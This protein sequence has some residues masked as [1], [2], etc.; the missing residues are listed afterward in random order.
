MGEITVHIATTCTG[1]LTHNV[2]QGDITV[3]GAPTLVQNKEQ[4]DIT[5]HIVAIIPP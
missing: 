3:H 2:E 4:G 5:I 1:I